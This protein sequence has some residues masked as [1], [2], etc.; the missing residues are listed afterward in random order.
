M[1]KLLCAI[2]MIAALAG[3]VV[4]PMPYASRVYVAPAP[5]YVA[6][7]YGTVIVGG[8]RHW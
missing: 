6:P 4:A 7:V 3:C 1:I 5:V 8:G 2:T